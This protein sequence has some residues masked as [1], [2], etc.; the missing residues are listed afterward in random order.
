M[1]WGPLWGFQQQRGQKISKAVMGIGFGCIFGV[2]WVIALVL[3]GERDFL[4]HS[5]WEWLDLTYALGIAKMLITVF[6]YIPQV[7]VNYKRR[8][9]VGW[10]IWQI[11]LDLIGGVLSIMQLVIDSSLQNDWSSLTGN[12][13]K[14]GLGNV[15]IFLDIVFMI[16]HYCIYNQSKISPEDDEAGERGLLASTNGSS[17][18]SNP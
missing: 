1:F 2:V 10:S 5:R 11:L 13:V 16:Q 14:L 7:H 18:S 4:V 6:K 12:P 17:R 9:T 8:S 3:I 15:S